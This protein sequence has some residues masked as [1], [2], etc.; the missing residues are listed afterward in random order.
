MN[1]N[2]CAQN[3]QDDKRS[4]ILSLDFL[5]AGDCGVHNCLAKVRRLAEIRWLLDL[6]PSAFRRPWWVMEDQLG[7]EHEEHSGIIQ[8]NLQESIGFKRG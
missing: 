5:P 2:F 4:L 8:E 7:V 1:A 6:A 3:K